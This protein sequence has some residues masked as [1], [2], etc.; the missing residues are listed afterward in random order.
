MFDGLERPGLSQTLAENAG[1]N[2]QLH[3]ELVPLISDGRCAGLDSVARRYPGVHVRAL[4]DDKGIAIAIDPGQQLCELFV[5]A[6]ELG[7]QPG[8]LFLLMPDCEFAAVESSLHL[9]GRI[10]PRL[11]GNEP[12]SLLMALRGFPGC[13]DAPA[14]LVSTARG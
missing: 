8:N 5:F 12:T 10:I 3:S 4:Q 2:T 6:L 14:T 9:H 1:T 11:A 13:A 7:P